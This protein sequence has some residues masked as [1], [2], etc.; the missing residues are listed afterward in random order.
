MEM[1]VT[2][3]K[4]CIQK[5]IRTLKKASIPAIDGYYLG[6]MSLRSVVDILLSYKRPRA[7]KLY[8]SIR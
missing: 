1:K 8:R 7:T 5:A 4:S 3:S 6:Q 2:F